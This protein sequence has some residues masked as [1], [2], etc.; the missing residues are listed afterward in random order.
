MA[1]E[2]IFTFHI[3]TTKARERKGKK[4]RERER[5]GVAVRKYSQIFSVRK[6]SESN[7]FFFY[8]LSWR[9]EGG[10]MVVRT[11]KPQ[12]VWDE[13]A[14]LDAFNQR[15]IKQKH[16]NKL[17]RCARS[18]CECIGSGERALMYRLPSLLFA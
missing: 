1:P 17:I 6:S 13:D 7:P 5:V 16:Y 15:G 10:G 12:S 3:S 8:L 2:T 11:L 9:E 18:D 14:L 4:K